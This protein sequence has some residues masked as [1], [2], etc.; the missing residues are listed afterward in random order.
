MEHVTGHN[1]REMVRECVKPETHMMTDESKR[2]HYLK[3]IVRSH[4][5]VNHS[6]KE[7]VR[8]ECHINTAES[9]HALLKRGVIGVYHHWSKKH[10]HR[11]LAEFDFRWNERK[12]S[13]G[14]RTIAAIRGI[15]GKRLKYK[16]SSQN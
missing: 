13:D 14:D 11:Y 7:Y 2:Y 3:Y 6:E 4:D 10:L 16:D 8:G 5:A 12:T 9:V 1:I 15:E